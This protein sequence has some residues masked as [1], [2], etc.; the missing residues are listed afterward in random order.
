MGA[1]RSTAGKLE[2]AVLRINGEGAWITA[3][4]LMQCQAQ[5]LDRDRD[6]PALIWFGEG[7]DMARILVQESSNRMY[8]ASLT[9]FAEST[10][11]WTVLYEEQ[12]NDKTFGT[13]RCE[14]E[15]QIVDLQTLQ[16]LT[17][18]KRGVEE[19]VGAGGEDDE[20]AP[21][22]WGTIARECDSG[23]WIEVRADDEQWRRAKMYR[24]RERSQVV[25]WQ[26]G[27]RAIESTIEGFDPAYTFN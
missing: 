1:I 13:W 21:G 11:A 5:D 3:K 20:D 15:T 17:H 7:A 14:R 19:H 24:H 18:E 16:V 2:Y 6:D 9:V 10:G 26:P 12:G 27:T 22:L 23:T 25:L 8:L 4:Q